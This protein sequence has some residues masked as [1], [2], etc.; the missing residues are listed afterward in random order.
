VVT[1]LD[2]RLIGAPDEEHFAYA[3]SARR[4]VVTS[5][6]ADFARLSKALLADGGHHPG[7]VV[8]RRRAVGIGEVINALARLGALD[9]LLMTDRVE[10]LSRWIRVARTDSPPEG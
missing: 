2:A 5:D 4:V 7:I 9:P 6:E 10:Y 8:A 3:R 1:A